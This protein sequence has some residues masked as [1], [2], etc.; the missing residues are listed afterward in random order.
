MPVSVLVPWRGG[1]PD[2]EA[3][4]AW[5]ERQWRTRFPHWEIVVGRCPDGPWRKAVAVADAASRSTGD[6]LVV[7]DADCWTDGVAEAVH[8]VTIGAT[9]WAIPHYHVH[10]LTREAT[11]A[12]LAGGEL[13]GETTRKPY[14][15]W[16]G[17]G[18]VILRRDTYQRVPMDPRFTGWGNED[19]AWALSL[20]CL[21]G[22][23]IR[24]TSPLFH[25]WHEPAPRM[26]SVFGSPESLALF[27]R[28]KRAAHSKRAMRDLLDEFCRTPVRS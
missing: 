4:W 27:K 16:A 6:V 28:Y 12:V 3:A 11:A 10:R 25:L 17:G 7:G 15:G 26:T 20:L 14:P 5:V 9:Q 8:V 21:S 24:G 23:A 19:S 18:M 13:H 1:D 2:R 22:Q